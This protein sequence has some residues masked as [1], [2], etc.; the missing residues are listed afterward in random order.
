MTKK[1][2]I[3]A[4]I[5][6]LIGIRGVGAVADFPAEFEFQSAGGRAAKRRQGGFRDVAEARSM[7]GVQVQGH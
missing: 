5:G 7:A 3:G 1:L 6:A 2:M 4:A